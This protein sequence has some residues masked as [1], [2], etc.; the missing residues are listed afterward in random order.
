MANDEQI[1]NKIFT[2][3]NLDNHHLEKVINSNLLLKLDKN[4]HF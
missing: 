1:E 4:Y 3:Q 2:I